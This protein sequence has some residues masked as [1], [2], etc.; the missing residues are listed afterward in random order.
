MLAHKTL[1]SIYRRAQ[2]FYSNDALIVLGIGMNSQVLPKKHRHIEAQLNKH[3]PKKK[4]SQ[5]TFDENCDGIHTFQALGVIK[6]ASSRQ[7]IPWA[8]IPCD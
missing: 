2:C 5:P 6:S 4:K 7:K 8:L 3:G 1:V